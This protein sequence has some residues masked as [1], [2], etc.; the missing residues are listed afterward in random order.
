[1]HEIAKSVMA[2]NAMVHFSTPAEQALAARLI[3]LEKQIARLASEVEQ[4]V[5]L[6]KTELTK[7]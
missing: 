5:T 2:E 3:A 7:S 4:L 1:M 6:V